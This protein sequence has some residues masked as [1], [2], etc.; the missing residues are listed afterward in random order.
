MKKSARVGMM[1]VFLLLL[2]GGMASAE[3]EGFEDTRMLA[4][5][6]GALISLL[7]DIVFGIFLVVG[8]GMIIMSLADS[9]K[10]G[11]GH[12]AVGL[13]MVLVCGVALFTISSLAGQDGQ[14]H[15][16]S[17]KTNKDR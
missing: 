11:F 2:A 3:G 5:K 17:I 10:Y 15:F 16:R 12:F 7:L 13:V 6:V 14:E 4:G 1:A 8:C 9:K